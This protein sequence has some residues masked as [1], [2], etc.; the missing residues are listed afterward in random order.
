MNGSLETLLPHCTR[1]Q[2][3]ATGVGMSI[4]MQ[5]RFNALLEIPSSAAI[6][7]HGRD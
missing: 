6:F 4:S 1:V 2:Y 5:I 3:P 7:V